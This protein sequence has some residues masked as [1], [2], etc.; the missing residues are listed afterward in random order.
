MANT[1]LLDL[2]VMQNKLSV[3]EGLSTLTNLRR[4][5]LGFNKI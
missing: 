4:L 3:I 5:N 1:N 2:S